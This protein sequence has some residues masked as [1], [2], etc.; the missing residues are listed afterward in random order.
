MPQLRVALAQID[1]TVGDLAGNVAAV[2]DR[3][4][5]A[6]AAGAH[7]VTFPEMAI[8][9]YPPED[10]VFRESFRTASRATV[11]KL[12]ADL[13]GAGL[14]D[15]AVVVGY[16]DE[17]GGP[18]N[19]AT[20]YL[21]ER[22]GPRN[23]AAFCLGG[24]V[25]ATYF[26]HHL[27]NFGVFD[28]ARYFVRGDRFTVVRYRGVDIA[29][30][31]CEDMWQEG[32][33]F[34]VAGQVGVGLVVNINGS[35][36]ERV[37]DGDSIVVGADGA[38]LARTPQFVEGLF[39]VDVEL[40]PCP[41]AVP[42]TPPNSPMRVEHHDTQTGPVR[43]HAAAPGD[44]AE[45]LV[46]EA[47]VWAALVTGTRDYVRKNGFRSVV[48]G[49]SGGI[50][51]AVVAAIAAD[52][53]GGDNVHG[54]SMPSDYSSEHSKS[55]AADLAE[56]LGAQY[57]V[58]AVAPM[59]DD[60]VESLKLIGLAEENVQARVRGTTLMALSNAEGHLVLATGNKSELAVGYSTIY[61]DAVGGF[62]PIKDV[63]KSLVWRLARW[64]NAD[65]QVRGQ[66][67]P[68]PPNSIEKPPSAELRPGQLDTD[69]L[70]D[71]ELLDASQIEAGVQCPMAMTYGAAAVLRHAPDLALYV[72][73]DAGLYDV[74][75]AGYDPELVSRIARLV[76][77][78]EWKRRQYPPGPKISFKS[79][80][81]DRRL[82]ISNR[83]RESK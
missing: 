21:D 14:G 47:E 67:P 34:A 37:F 74:I 12:A 66:I 7:L 38:V 50:D 31:I 70:P 82:P 81:R 28:E 57:R 55:D 68:I 32:G 75:A 63:P 42:E 8:T 41:S 58:V 2:L 56:R 3:T 79:F 78:A 6:A 80:G 72:D 49:M 10:L 64:R 46:D 33:P 77:S 5:E 11:E 23:A 43:A 65:A 54:V 15:I 40:P 39:H 61:G 30:T 20:L 36:Y 9:G 44:I 18:H 26:K 19:S 4:R 76:D 59:I 83:W 16:L 52:A 69:S 51:S 25:V 73:G 35:P 48:L 1:V 60:F 24:R 53:I 13:A 27:P 29:L 45:R 17:D 62:A 22:A 71:Y